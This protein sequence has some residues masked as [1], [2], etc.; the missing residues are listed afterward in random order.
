MRYFNHAKTAL[1]NNFVTVLLKVIIKASEPDLMGH[2]DAV[3]RCLVAFATN[4]GRCGS[5]GGLHFEGCFS[6][7]EGIAR[8]AHSPTI[9][10]RAVRGVSRPRTWARPSGLRHLHPRRAAA[11]LLA[12]PRPPG[13]QLQSFGAWS[14]RLGRGS[15]EAA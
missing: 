13:R 2:E 1:L 15:T 3:L 4:D 14:A 6:T 10:I 9:P 12:E 11:T 8:P 7:R 5:R